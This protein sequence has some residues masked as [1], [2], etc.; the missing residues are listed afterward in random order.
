MNYLL[1][2]CQYMISYSVYFPNIKINTFNPIAQ[3]KHN[4]NFRN[5]SYGKC[6]VWLLEYH[7]TLK[8]G[9]TNIFQNIVFYKF[10]YA[11]KYYKMIGQYQSYIAHCNPE[12]PDI[13]K[14]P[15]LVSEWE[16][17]PCLLVV[18]RCFQLTWQKCA[19]KPIYLYVASVELLLPNT[20]APVTPSHQR[21]FIANVISVM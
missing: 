21:H 7:C 11:T 3:T 6:V 14:M 2:V 16:C 8:L 12:Y 5:F 15:K 9:F 13:Y 18:W 4:R 20:D 17:T 1:A 10:L 19:T